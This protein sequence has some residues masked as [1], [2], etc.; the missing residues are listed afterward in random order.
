MPRYFIVSLTTA[1]CAAVPLM[2]ADVHAGGA[3]ESRRGGG[4]QSCLLLEELP[5]L[6]AQVGEHRLAL[7]ELVLHVGLLAAQDDLLGEGRL[8]VLLDGLL[9][10]ADAAGELLDAGH[11]V[12]SA[13]LIWR[14]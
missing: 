11:R 2:R 13:R 5:D 10:G 14:K 8:T 4:V 12:V 3:G 1:T 7:S 6:T 9:E